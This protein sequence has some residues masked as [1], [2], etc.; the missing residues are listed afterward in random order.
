MDDV[1]GEEVI[2]YVGVSTDWLRLGTDVGVYI[3][4]VL[5]NGNGVLLVDGRDAMGNLCGDLCVCF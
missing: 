2:N 3:F 1:W 5:T 4:V